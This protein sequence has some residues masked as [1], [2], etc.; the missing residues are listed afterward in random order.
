MSSINSL[1][2]DP[3]KPKVPIIQ[4][5]PKSMKKIQQKYTSGRGQ[6]QKI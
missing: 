3:K 6:K 1:N 2:L 5:P 4:E